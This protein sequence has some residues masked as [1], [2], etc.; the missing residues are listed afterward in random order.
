MHLTIKHKTKSQKNRI[1]QLGSLLS[2]AMHYEKIEGF[3]L[4]I[5]E[6]PC[7]LNFFQLYG[8]HFDEAIFA[9]CNG[10][11]NHKKDLIIKIIS[12]CNNHS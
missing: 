12:L 3:T 2:H 5:G 8:C 10:F 1:I 11:T 4:I 9:N 6:R 7:S